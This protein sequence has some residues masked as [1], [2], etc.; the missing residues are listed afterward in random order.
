[1][2][3]NLSKYFTSLES[4]NYISKQIPQVVKDDGQVV[5]DQFKTLDETKSF[6]ENLYKKRKIITS[7]VFITKFKKS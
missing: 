5:S 4:R 2:E 1:M 3:R 7:E 6:Y